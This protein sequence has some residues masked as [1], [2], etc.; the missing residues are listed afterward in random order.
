MISLYLAGGAD[1]ECFWRER[2]DWQEQTTLLPGRRSRSRRSRRRSSRACHPSPTG[3]LV[4]QGR[5]GEGAQLC[6]IAA[7]VLTGLE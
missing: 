2:V 5:A 6:P 1:P 4:T 7:P 3:L